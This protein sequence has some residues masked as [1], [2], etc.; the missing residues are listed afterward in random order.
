MNLVGNAIFGK[1]IPAAVPYSLITG[2]PQGEARRATRSQKSVWEIAPDKRPSIPESGHDS[3]LC[4]VGH[5]QPGS[6]STL[7]QNGPFKEWRSSRLYRAS[8]HLGPRQEGFATTTNVTQRQCCSRGF[9]SEQH[10]C[11]LPRRQLRHPRHSCRIWR[12]QVIRLGY[13]H[14]RSL[15]SQ[16]VH[17]PLWQAS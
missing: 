11:L 10:C 1:P 15:D 2:N 17:D 5:P 7:P 13:Q 8:Q 6:R 16:C 12:Q 4:P 9:H 14:A 3:R